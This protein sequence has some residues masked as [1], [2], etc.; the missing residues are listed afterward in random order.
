M[1]ASVVRQANLT[2]AGGQNQTRINGLGTKDVP[3]IATYFNS[4]ALHSDHL[5]CPVAAIGLR[6]NLRVGQ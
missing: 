4:G 2:Y 3:T 1:L 6:L 5:C